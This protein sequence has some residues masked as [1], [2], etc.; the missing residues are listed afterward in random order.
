MNLLIIKPI[1][2]LNPISYKDFRLGVGQLWEIYFIL[3]NWTKLDMLNN[4]SLYG[5]K[6]ERLMM[7]HIRNWGNMF[8]GFSWRVLCGQAINRIP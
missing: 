5:N 2:K 8:G 6:P 3:S 7:W 1:P 4:R